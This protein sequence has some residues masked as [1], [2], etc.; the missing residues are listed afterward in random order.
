VPTAATDGSPTRPPPAIGRYVALGDSYTAAPYV[1]LT[2]VANGCLRSD[3]NYPAQLAKRLRARRMVDVSCSGATSLDLLQRQRTFQKQSVAPQLDA[4]TAGTDLVTI[5]MG[6][7]DFGLFGS[8]VGT[9]PISGPGGQVFAP[10][11]G[12]RCGQVDVA[13]ARSDVAAIGRLLTRDLRRIHQRAPHATVVLVGYPRIV[14]PGARC[15]RTVPVARGDAAQLDTVT[16]LLST[17]MRAAAASTGTRY[18]DLYAASRGHDACAGKQAWV[19][20]V[21]TDTNRAAALH[22]FVEEQTAVADLIARAVD[23]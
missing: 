7:N 1:Y 2:D 12:V 13:R 17:T 20:G 18:V 10:E 23:R 8:L 11:K 16:R 6:G 15:P 22:P 9:C 4:V 3:N 19:N 14:S 5:G 21:H